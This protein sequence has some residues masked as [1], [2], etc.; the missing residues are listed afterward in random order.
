MA[1]TLA[2]AY[3]VR[4][5]GIAEY[6]HSQLLGMTAAYRVLETRRLAKDLL[7]GYMARRLLVHRATRGPVV[8]AVASGEPWPQKNQGPY[9]LRGQVSSETVVDDRTS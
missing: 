1:G 5:K 6:C 2:R 4:H 3:S 7:L 8:R 9:K